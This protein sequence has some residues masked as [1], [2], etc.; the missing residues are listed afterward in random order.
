MSCSCVTSTIVMASSRFSFWKQRE[1]LEAGARIQ[2]A[3]GLVGE[4]QRGPV[5]QRAGDRDALL[6]AAGEL[7]RQVALAALEADRAQRGARALA[8]LGG[9]DAAVDERQLDVLERARARDEVEALEDEAELAVA[10]RRALVGG[11]ARD[12]APGEAVAPARR[13]DRGSR[14]RS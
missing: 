12:V 3:G 5:H 1:Q 11:E 6:L 9:R 13:R 10:D 2:V 8:L 4:Q 14:A 7:A